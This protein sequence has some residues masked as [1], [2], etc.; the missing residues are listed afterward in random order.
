MLSEIIPTD[1][2]ILI[3]SRKKSDYNLDAY[4][5]KALKFEAKVFR[6]YEPNSKSVSF[7]PGVRLSLFSIP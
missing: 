6:H 7:T 2:I 3:S 5:L 1:K 4:Y